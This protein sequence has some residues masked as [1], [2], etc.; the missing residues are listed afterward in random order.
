MRA[1]CQMFYLIGALMSSPYVVTALY[2]FVEF[3]DYQELQPK[4]LTL[5]KKNKV[6]GTLL[7][8]AEGINGT[9]AGSREGIDTV[10]SFI[11]KH[12]AFTEGLEYKESLASEQPFLR[13][14]IRL[15]KEIVTLGIEDISPVKTVGTYIDPQD[16]NAL[17][18]NDEVVL[19]D[20][21]NDYEYEIG[22]FKVHLIQTRKLSGSFPNILNKTLI[23]ADT[24]ESQL[25]AQVASGAKKQ[26]RY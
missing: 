17:I 18:Q 16:W 14:K 11:R 26:P 8:A 5:C 7:L 21:R 9:I 10:I 15:K 22:T 6:Y 20:C 12:P 4:L 25:S 2:K 1:K 13:T 24:N 19:I 3:P 23:R